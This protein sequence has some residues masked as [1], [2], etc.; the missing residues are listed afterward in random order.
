[1]ARYERIMAMKNFPFARTIWDYQ[2][3]FS[4]RDIYVPV[5]AYIDLLKRLGFRY[6]LIPDSITNKETA[7]NIYISH[8]APDYVAY[9]IKRKG[10]TD[11]L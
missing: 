11:V 3:R 10:V 8:R 2:E 6:N 7:T 1:M 9:A 4:G 5:A